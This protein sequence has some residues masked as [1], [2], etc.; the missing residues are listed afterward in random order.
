MRSEEEKYEPLKVKVLTTSLR[1][2]NA[3]FMVEKWWKPNPL[4]LR[5]ETNRNRWAN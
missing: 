5:L 1:V 3:L 4:P 2:Y